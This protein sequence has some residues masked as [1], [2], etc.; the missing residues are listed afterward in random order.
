[1]LFPLNAII[2]KEKSK[3]SYQ[4][5]ILQCVNSKHTRKRNLKPFIYRTEAG[6]WRMSL[7]GGIRCNE[8]LCP[9]QSGG[10]FLHCTNWSSISSMTAPAPNAVEGITRLFGFCVQVRFSNIRIT[11]KAS[12][13][14]VTLM[15]C[16]TTL[17]EGLF[18]LANFPEILISHVILI[19]NQEISPMPPKILSN[20]KK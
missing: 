3:L 6:V 5:I 11:L 18:P 2:K 16:L 19:T 15:N 9:Y 17:R 10:R 13:V 1:M 8:L 20:S 12:K 14:D 7:I 4:T